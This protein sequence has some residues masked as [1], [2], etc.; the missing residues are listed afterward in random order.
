M[1]ATIVQMVWIVGGLDIVM[2][3]SCIVAK[4]SLRWSLAGS[5]LIVCLFIMYFDIVRTGCLMC[6]NAISHEIIVHRIKLFSKFYILSNS[7]AGTT[8]GAIPSIS[9]AVGILSRPSENFDLWSHGVLKYDVY[10]SPRLRKVYGMLWEV[11]VNPFLGPAAKH[12]IPQVRTYV[13]YNC[14]SHSLSCQL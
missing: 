11:V 5:P 1:A 6:I 2:H 7:P 13:N 9:S 14:M 3:V 10:G 4:L 8:E 12:Y